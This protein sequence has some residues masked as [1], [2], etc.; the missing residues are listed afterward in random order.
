MLAVFWISAIQL[1]TL[2]NLSD[3]VWP[4]HQ[5]R[6]KTWTHALFW[7]FAPYRNAF[8]VFKW[9]YFFSYQPQDELTTTYYKGSDDWEHAR[10]TSNIHVLLSGILTY[11]SSPRLDDD[12]TPAASLL[13]NLGHAFSGLLVGV[14]SGTHCNLVLDPTQAIQLN[15]PFTAKTKRSHWERM[16]DSDDQKKEK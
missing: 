15:A 13:L 4:I 16:E 2:N 10:P 7:I 9:K 6:K 3:P 8:M 1:Q 5:Q 14:I 12:G 11:V